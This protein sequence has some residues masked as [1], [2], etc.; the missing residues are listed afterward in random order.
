MPVQFGYV[1]IQLMNK[2]CA[3]FFVLA[4][5]SSFMQLLF[6]F[7]HIQNDN[8]FSIFSYFLKLTRK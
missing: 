2:V 8:H 6:F 1:F 5:L 7:P 4:L 3:F